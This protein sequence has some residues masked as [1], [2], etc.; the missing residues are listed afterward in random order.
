[1]PE[2]AA[3]VVLL[4]VVAGGVIMR[5]MRRSREYRAMRRHFHPE[6]VRDT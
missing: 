1:M 4:A 2:V 6:R 3:M 5:S